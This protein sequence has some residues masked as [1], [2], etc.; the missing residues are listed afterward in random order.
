[1][2]LKKPKPKPTV[3]IKERANG[4]KLITI[5]VIGSDL[6]RDKDGEFVLTNKEFPL[7]VLFEVVDG[8]E[9]PA[10]ATIR[11]AARPLRHQITQI[12]DVL[13]SRKEQ[14]AMHPC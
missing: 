12:A 2:P 7:G 6:V 1:M 14:S 13:Q 9:C 10:F 5:R 11:I 8:V 4:S 3:H